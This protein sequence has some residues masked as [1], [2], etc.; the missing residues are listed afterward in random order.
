MTTAT[1]TVLKFG[2]S[3]LRSED[4]L[5][6]VVHEIYRYW[7]RGS[8][9][10]A[11]VSA[12]GG[13]TDAL[14]EKSRTYA[15]EPHPE[16]LASLLFTGETTS[17]ALLALALD[18]SGIPARLLSPEQ[19]GLRTNGHPLDAE[20]IDVNIERLREELTNAVVIISGFAGVDQQGALTLL[21]RGG[22]DYTALFLAERL[23]ARCVLLKDVDGLY[24]SHPLNGGSRRYS[25]S[26]YQTVLR[27]GGELVQPKAVDFAERHG[28]EFSIATIGS[29]EQTIVGAG[30][31]ELATSDRTYKGK[32]RVALLGCGTVG[33]GVYERLA[34]LPD[35]FEIV[36]V[37]NLDPNKAMAGGIDPRHIERDVERLIS[38]DCDVIIE[39]IGGVE[40]A[41]AYVEKALKLGRHVVTANKALL[42]E[43]GESLRNLAEENGVT[44][45]YSASVGGALPALEAVA[46]TTE[47]PRSITGIINGTCNFIFDKLGAGVDLDSAVK[48]AQDQG[49]A[50][51]DPTLDLDG[52]DAAQKLI[53]LIRESFGVNLPLH[54]VEREGVDR[55]R[56][57]DVREASKRGNIF[58]LIAECSQTSDGVRASVRPFEVSGSHRFAMTK[59]AQNCL[60]IEN[61]DG[62]ERVLTGRGAGRYATTEAVIADLFD[63]RQIINHAVRCREVAA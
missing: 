23:R 48:L 24:E 10:L 47:V 49:F 36:G 41:R 18:R 40:P 43:A 26:T 60:V 51:A 21:G 62:S 35:L 7:R 59:G 22:T 45:R 42:A 33:G 27:V 25:N 5:P 53:L 34:S 56:Q 38:K 19:A 44:I 39:L 12:F 52:T 2:G 29:D 32:V 37:V 61:S 58:R 9:V 55:V 50:E 1:T 3:V 8:Q 13:H 28:Q 30:H 57:T 15:E 11:V 20:P 4:D 46:Q 63:V 31:D 16:A 14:L 6:R 17:A 54:E